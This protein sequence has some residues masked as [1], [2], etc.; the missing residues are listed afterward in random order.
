MLRFWSYRQR[1]VDDAS[2]ASASAEQQAAW[3]E[4]EKA[5]LEY[6]FVPEYLSAQSPQ[7]GA[8]VK[9]AGTFQGGPVTWREKVVFY[10]KSYDSVWI[11]H[12]E[13]LARYLGA[14]G[15]KVL[16]AAP[17]AEWMKKATRE[18]AYGTVCVMTHGLCPGSVYDQD[19]VKES[20]IRKYLEAG[21]RVV[22]IG[23]MPFLYMEDDVHPQIFIGGR[24]G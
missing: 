21:G 2:L 23:E 12:P 10:D 14:N 1:Q 5:R 11:F 22:W 20:P 19:N 24:S 15:F 3:K 17:F 13:I 9:P 7:P 18:G 4:Q 16:E 8:P 6:G